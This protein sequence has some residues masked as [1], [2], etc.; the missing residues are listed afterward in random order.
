M[1]DFWD[2]F[3]KQESGYG[4]SRS[5][6]FWNGLN[7]TEVVSPEK[8]S[9]NPIRRLA[10]P[11]VGLVKD[12]AVG[13][14]ETVVG[15][16]DIPTMGYA[17]KVAE[18]VSRG[19]GLGDFKSANEMFDNLLTPETREAQ[20]KVAEAKGFLPTIAT[21]IQNPSSIV[22]TV[23]ESIPSMFTG[24][25]A[26]GVVS[27]LIGK[28]LVEAGIKNL[29]RIAKVGGIA[30]GVITA[31]Q[32]TEQ[33]RQQ[34]EEG[35]LTPSQVGIN[36]V[37]GILTGILGVT[38]ARLAKWLKIDD[39]DMLYTAGRNGMVGDAEKNIFKKVLKGAFQEGVLEELPQSMQEQI[40][41]NLALNKPIDDG[42]FEAGAMGMLAGFAQSTGANIAG[43]TMQK[44]KNELDPINQTIKKIADETLPGELSAIGGWDNGKL[45]ENITPTAVSETPSRLH[46]SEIDYGEEISTPLPTPTESF[47]ESFS[48]GL[49]GIARELNVGQ[50]APLTAEETGV[51]NKIPVAPEE[52]IPTPE[53]KV[54]AIDK[55]ES[56][57]ERRKQLVNLRDNLSRKADEQNKQDPSFPPAEYDSRVEEINSV[58][59][60]GDLVNRKANILKGNTQE[61]LEEIHKNGMAEV[62]KKYH[63][64]IP[65]ETT[66]KS[67]R[68]TGKT[69]DS[70][71]VKEPW[72]MTKE[73]YAP[74]T[75]AKLADVIEKESEDAPKEHIGDFDDLRAEYRKYGLI[76][77][78]KGNEYRLSNGV[79]ATPR[80][81]IIGSKER[82][83]RVADN[84]KTYAKYIKNE[85]DEIDAG[86]RKYNH[87][88]II[89]QALKE[90]K[91]VPES[92]LKEYPDLVPKKEEE[93]TRK[94]EDSEKV[95]K[96]IKSQLVEY[97][98]EL[99][100]RLASL[101]KEKAAAKST[102]ETDRLERLIST[103]ETELDRYLREKTL[104][105]DRIDSIR[106]AQTEIA[107]AGGKIPKT[108]EEAQIAIDNYETELIKKY[109]EKAVIEAPIGKFESGDFPYGKSPLSEPDLAKLNKLYENRDNIDKVELDKWHK[110]IYEKSGLSK[111]EVDGALKSLNMPVGSDLSIPFTAEGLRK[112][113]ERD[114]DNL[115]NLYNNFSKETYADF[116]F[117]DNPDNPVI[118]GVVYN[119]DGR[120]GKWDKEALKKTEKLFNTIGE[121]QG[122]EPL[123]LL[124]D[125]ANKEITKPPIT[126]QEQLKQRLAEG[127]RLAAEKR[128]EAAGKPIAKSVEAVST[129]EPWQTSDL[130]VKPNI[131]IESIHALKQSDGK[132][133]LFYRGTRNEV[134]PGNTFNSATD[135][136]NFFSVQ[137]NKELESNQQKT[138]VSNTKKVSTETKPAVNAQK[139]IT[140]ADPETLNLVLHEMRSGLETGTPGGF[141]GYDENGNPIYMK[142]GYQGWFS[143]LVKKYGN[144]KT[145]PTGEKESINAKYL[146]NIINKGLENDKLT[147]KQN[148]IWEDVNKIADH[149]SGKTYA[150]LVNQFE[151]IRELQNETRKQ[152]AEEEINAGEIAESKDDLISGAS[153]IL[154][155]E[156]YSSEQLE[157]NVAEITSFFDEMSKEPSATKQSWEQTR[158]EFVGEATGDERAIRL[159]AHAQHV[160]QAIADG[161]RVPLE[162]LNNYKNNGWAQI[163]IDKIKSKG[164]VQTELA[165][166][167]SFN[168]ANPAAPRGMGENI[169]EV[170][171]SGNLFTEGKKKES[172]IPFNRGGI[173][174]LQQSQVQS[175][176]DQALKSISTPPKVN[177]IQSNQD[178]PESVQKIMEEYEIDDAM[179]FTHNGEVYLVANNIRNE[180]EILRTMAHE[181]THSGLGKFFQR[182]TQSKIMPVRA[183]Y[184][185]LMDAI[186]RA[187]TEEVEQLSKT[188]HTH[189]N[190]RTVQGRR[191]ACEEW[192]CNQS[193][194]SQPKWYDKLVAIFNDLLR[195]VGLNV[196]L[197]DAEVRVVL[198]DAFKEFGGEGVNF[199][200]AHHGTPH[201]W[202]PEPGF[203][204]G[205]PRLDKIGTG[206]GVAAFGWGWYSAEAEGV[207]EEYRKQL[208][209]EKIQTL[210]EPKSLKIN[211]ERIFTQERTPRK[212]AALMLN[213]LGGIEAIR[214][215]ED[216]AS[217]GDKFDKDVL[218]SLY[219]LINSN[220]K[221]E[222]EEHDPGSL[223]KLEI[224][225]DVIPKLLD[226]DKQVGH[227]IWVKIL[228]QMRAENRPEIWHDSEMGKIYGLR[229]NERGYRIYSS[230]SKTLGSDKAASN[231]LARAGIP[232]NKYLDWMSRNKP[233]ADIKKA[234]LDAIPE[235]ADFHEVMELIGT[236]AFTTEQ[237]R[238]LRAINDNDWLGFDYPSQAISAAFSKNLS[239][240][241]ASL[242]LLNSI[243]DL[244]NAN[245]STYNFVIWDQKVL[246]RIALLERNGEKLDAIREE[247]EQEVPIEFQRSPVR[248]SQPMFSRSDNPD[249]KWWE[250][251][252]IRKQLESLPFKFWQ[253]PRDFIADGYVPITRAEADKLYYDGMDIFVARVDLKGAETTGN[254]GWFMHPRSSFYGYQGYN[255]DETYYQ[256][257]KA[258]E[259]YQKY[260]KRYSLSERGR[261]DTVQEGMRADTGIQD[262]LQEVAFSRRMF[263]D[264][265]PLDYISSYIPDSLSSWFKQT[266]TNSVPPSDISQTNGT[267]EIPASSTMNTLTYIMAD[268]NIDLRDI[269]KSIEKTHG[270]LE[271]QKNTSLK[272]TLFSGRLSSRL[273]DFVNNEL[274]SVISAMAKN[275]ISIAQIEE[276]LHARHAEEANDYLDSL[277]EDKRKGNAGI[278]TEDANDYLDSL[279]PALKEKYEKIALM[280]DKI[281]H[282][283][284][285]LLVDYGLESQETIDKWFNKYKHYVPLFRED[286]EERPGTG[287]GFTVAGSASKGRTGSERKVVHILSNIAMQRE[288]TLTRG[289]KNRVSQSLV[290]LAENFPNEDFWKIIKIPRLSAFI[291]PG[292]EAK[293]KPNV[294]VARIKDEETGEIK[295][296]GVQFNENNKRAMRMATALKN[297]DMDNIGEILGTLGKITRYVSAIN[298]Q[299]NPVFGVTNFF[300][301]MGT[302]AFNLSTTKI[303]GKQKKVLSNVL[304]AM[305]GIWQATKGNESSEMAKLFKDFQLHGGQTGYR[306]LF[307]VSEDRAKDIERELKSLQAGKPRRYLSAFAKILSDY[308]TM[309]EN[310]IRLSAYKVGIE[311]GMT[312]DKAASM[313]KNLT[314]NFNK[315]GQI[316]GQA[317]ALYAFFNASVQGA[318]RMYETL[319]GPKGYKIIAGG[320]I[321]GAAQAMMLAAAGFKDEE[322][323]EFVK[324]R[325]VI[326]PIG[327]KKYITF[328]MP[329]GFNVI[330]NVGRILAEITLGGG[331]NAGVKMSGLIGIIM[332]T[333]N[334][335]GSSGLSMQTVA[336][337]FLDPFAALAE[338]KN[339]TGRP[340][341]K[342]DFN[343]LNPTPGTSRVKDSATALGRGLAWAFNILTG[344]NKYTPGL[345]S[346]TPDQIDYLSGQITGGLGREIGKTSMMFESLYT[347]EELPAYKLPLTGRFYGTVEGQANES[348]KYYSNLKKLNVH[349]ANIKGRIKDREPVSQYI[350]DNPEAKLWRMANTV[351][352]TISRIK[353]RRE[354]ARTPE[355][356]KIYDKLITL[357]MKRLNN[358]VEKAG[359]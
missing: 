153:E 147:S 84:L 59:E 185:V 336:P 144:K 20:Q 324:E 283:N 268:R 131:K 222:I 112:F 320:I 213:R 162:V 193:Y 286:I 312:K 170:I 165:G 321:L 273:D 156:G 75:P 272:E 188:T 262:G 56:W 149:E 146:V 234:F 51:E 19:L 42:V 94:T 350:K 342:E 8:P 21:A 172:D 226:W 260:S 238:V 127:K 192:L 68:K 117:S 33:T 23:A 277:P 208:L 46:P 86:E 157:S 209:S 306:N 278:S 5:G 40:A 221:I 330:P 288:R 71:K 243:S 322:P 29:P 50:F 334:P 211:G 1:A 265:K 101:T 130:A 87:K 169:K 206:E 256:N 246:D 291:A 353:K 304:P 356:K 229:G 118:Q 289:E 22:Q 182:Q 359:G 274:H 281:T 239:N 279:D 316:A 142:S 2:D 119:K 15:L 67:E 48:T 88:G 199:K 121:T 158:E 31:G 235:D 245:E 173:S 107:K 328:P 102:R 314:V 333:F 290:S 233:L 299:Y 24:L 141:Q 30:E 230:L 77:S 303:A 177:I 135:A 282:K 175:V 163:A 340:I 176:I 227:K 348:N 310:S 152:L 275:G 62:L 337:T 6:D 218:D 133:K 138:Y 167:D 179:G 16:L 339:W 215:A 266:S 36:T 80:T 236:G 99:I 311:S 61:K 83:N 181:L 122:R 93:K 357:Q 269:V 259:L 3:D 212:N 251:M 250:G 168:L 35:T 197:S 257:K 96:A 344:G 247:Q 78:K 296:I 64:L 323:P 129:K 317:G 349:E 354:S 244:K 106:L 228:T 98:A 217:Y 43:S 293:I 72:K 79:S 160:K 194:E 55:K 52:N 270:I 139:K 210:S 200:I 225:D 12:T 294:V 39:V 132:F 332:E 267:W 341:Y 258:K 248:R 347:G 164:D 97:K 284:A 292:I 90:G 27:K 308:N 355:A 124:V 252:D 73:E 201:I 204:H 18:T 159:A 148:I 276:Y 14:P 223:Y 280:L 198:Q 123:N 329:L 315:K 26:A 219:E 49:Q 261:K 319:K 58:I 41:Q 44:M 34:T 151:K 57:Q 81:L 351:E 116:K 313:A 241:E 28:P 166:T 302:A 216:N 125:I 335:L 183:E 54:E 300:R 297:M 109:G 184:E 89:E 191:Q 255:Y 70:E 13:I 180:E 113:G 285:Q 327:D 287:Q 155:S 140:E 358:M 85:T 345:F 110:Y 7:D 307:V 203:P 161:E 178:C 189:L 346:P 74:S 45:V 249:Y 186:Y 207:G 171:P 111:Q 309:S 136:R 264:L 196:K 37:S 82:I 154:E 202:M 134:F 53:R 105:Q 11:L 108:S 253:K 343:S 4:M 143:D 120:P 114:T 240:Y 63:D 195:A 242:E 47:P 214:A 352:N 326:I 145:S 220:T 65:S 25:R 331:K 318:V 137:K 91:L 128:T 231:F 10:D 232:G 301:D 150:G 325:N 60:S 17:G 205:R 305:K 254:E 115:K 237:E 271:D 174:G 95:K 92:I 190:T 126:N 103:T 69:E 66:R 298:T 32:N 38:G 224:P 100:N 338:N 9:S 263:G 104:P 187:H 295:H 76:L